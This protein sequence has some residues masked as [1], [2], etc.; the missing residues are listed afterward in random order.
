MLLLPFF[1]ALCWTP[2]FG[3]VPLSLTLSPD[4]TSQA[5]EQSGYYQADNYHSYTGTDLIYTA[6]IVG[7]NDIAASNARFFLLLDGSISAGTIITLTS[8]A[9]LGIQP[10]VI[11]ADGISHFYSDSSITGNEPAFDSFAGVNPNGI[12]TLEFQSQSPNTVTSVQLD[13][14]GQYVYPTPAVPTLYFTLI[15]AGLESAGTTGKVYMTIFGETSSHTLVLSSTGI[16]KGPQHFSI[17]IA[18]VGKPVKF[19]INTYSSDNLIVETVSYTQGTWSG[20]ATD[21]QTTVGGKEIF[22]YV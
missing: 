22:Y 16:D 4:P 15:T 21:L 20:S 8:P 17:N 9:S 6:N 7:Q 13:W 14:G 12:W 18:A 5:S 1:F 3:I 19:G 11:T 10:V 2:S